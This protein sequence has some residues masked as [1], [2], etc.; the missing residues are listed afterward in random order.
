MDVHLEKTIEIKFKMAEKQ[1]LQLEY[2]KSSIS[3]IDQQINDI[4]TKLEKDEDI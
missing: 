3:D 2:L 4:L 1:N